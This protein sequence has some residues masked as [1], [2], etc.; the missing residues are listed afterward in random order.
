MDVYGFVLILVIT[1]IR[2]SVKFM[3][4]F[5]SSP[6]QFK[7]YKLPC[8]VFYLFIYV[9]RLRMR[10]IIRMYHCFPIRC[11]TWCF[12]TRLGGGLLFVREHIVNV[13]EYTLSTKVTF[14]YLVLEWGL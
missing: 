4:L 14:Q 12:L 5:F 10:G 8:F 3:L 9:S 2:V 1:S 7:L 6:P 13:S 11:M